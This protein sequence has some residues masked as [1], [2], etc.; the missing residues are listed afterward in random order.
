MLNQEGT[1]GIGDIERM[2]EKYA[3]R[4]NRID[5]SDRT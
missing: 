5:K 4:N 3:A 2:E 1:G